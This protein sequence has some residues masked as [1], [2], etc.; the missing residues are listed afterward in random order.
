MAD[1]QKKKN[2]NPQITLT[3]RKG[4]KLNQR[5]LGCIKPRIAEPRELNTNAFKKLF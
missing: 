1:S 4:L 5:I 2:R 3:Q